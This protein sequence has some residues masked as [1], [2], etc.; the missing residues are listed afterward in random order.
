MSDTLPLYAQLK[1]III[2]DIQAGRLAP[3]NQ[4]P[5]QRELCRRHNMS[6]MTVRRALD[7]LKNLAEGK[8][9]EQ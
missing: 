2:T 8:K 9:P 3:G 5:S 7:E 4:L 1:E 6:H